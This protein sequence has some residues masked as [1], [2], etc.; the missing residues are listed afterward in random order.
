MVDIQ[1][2]FQPDYAV[3]PGEVLGVELELRG[4]TQQELARRTGITPKHIISILKAKSA[5]TPE[6]AIK[7]ER[8]L[9]MPVE[10]WLNLEAHYQEILARVAEEDQLERDLD[11]LKHIPINAMVKMNWIDKIKDKKGQLIEVLR[12]FGIANVEQWDEMWP[13]L[14]VAY[15]QNQTHEVFPEAVSAWLRQGELK[16]SSIA[17]Q[18]YNKAKFREI[19]DEIRGLT[20]EDPAHFV[21]AMQEL[22]SMAGVA[23][24]FVPA[25]PK[26]GVSGATRWLNKDKAIIQLSLRYKTDDHLWFTFFHE[27]GHIL[28]H[29][30]KELFL[31]GTNGLDQEKEH[32]ANAFAEH[33]LIP[34]KAFTKFIADRDFKKTSISAF[35]KAIGIAPGIVVGQLQHKGLLDVKFCNDLKQRFKWAHE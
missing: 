16:A 13:N 24:V 30:K 23:V 15:R 31:E 8:A 17:C 33:E 26:T 21:P 6:T 34:T 28:R 3:S 9:G 18:P 20:T 22:C 35:S 14:N 2:E 19:L 5:I 25:L 11:W 1:N 4:M 27:A 12:F 32:E 7:F 29:G 10:Y